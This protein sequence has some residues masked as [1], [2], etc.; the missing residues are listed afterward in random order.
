MSPKNEPGARTHL[1]HAQDHQEFAEDVDEIEEEIHAVPAG[2][3]R[4]RLGG[5][6]AHPLP[7]QIRPRPPPD[8]I[9]VA[10]L[11]LLDDELRVEEHEAAHEHQPQVEV[12]LV[13]REKR[14]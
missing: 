12:G 4:G 5:V 2:R 3:E 6:L 11:C 14:C 9:L 1:V 13:G 8:V 10:A 7:S